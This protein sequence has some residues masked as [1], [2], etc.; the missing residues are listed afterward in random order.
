MFSNL[1]TN[2]GASWS[3]NYLIASGD[4]DKGTPGTDDVATSP[5]Y[6]RTYLVWTRFLNPFPIVSSFTTNGG[7]NWTSINQINVTPSGYVSLGADIKVNTGGTVCVCW[8]GVLTSSPQNE[9]FCGFANSTNGGVNWNVSEN[10][11]A[12][13]GVK[14]SSLQPWNIRINGYPHIETDRTGGIRNGWIYIVTGEKNLSPA[15]TDPDVVFHRSTDGGNTWSPG[16][17][18]NQDPINNGKVQY[19]PAINVDDQGGINVVYYDNRNI[20][21]DSMDVYISRSTNGGD[22]WSDYRINDHRF[23]PKTVTGSVGSG[24]QGDNIGITSVGNKLW[25]VWMDDY[26][27]N[28]QIWTASIDLNT[29]GITQISDEVPDGF[30]LEQNYPN[31]FNPSTV[32]RYSLIEN[33][34]VKLKV[35]DVLGNEIASLVN[36]KQNRG[37]YNYQF[38]TVNYQLPSGVYYYTLQ[39]GVSSITKK[40]L[41]LK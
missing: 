30:S 39:A 3:T 14:T 21:S 11:Y 19:F 4:Q 12:M 8:A 26:T 18:V 34:F 9:K 7:V 5:F 33:S 1:S 6:G 31:P 38:S 29:I 24:N 35:Y 16:V 41:L 28:Y 40:M 10:I 17:R 15:G 25:P 32:I 20:I 22:N 27:G 37:S 36:E 23:V 13:N 2:F